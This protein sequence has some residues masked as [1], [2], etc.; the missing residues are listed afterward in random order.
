MQIKVNKKC[1]KWMI[2][3]RLKWKMLKRET[4]VVDCAIRKLHQDI[5]SVIM[6]MFGD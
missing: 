4:Q 1:L 6:L 3:L 2:Y 5:V